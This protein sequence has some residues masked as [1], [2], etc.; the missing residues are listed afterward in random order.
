M[1]RKEPPNE[2]T[3]F[4]SSTTAEEGPVRTRNIKRQRKRHTKRKKRRMARAS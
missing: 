4:L 3:D 1:N 2:F